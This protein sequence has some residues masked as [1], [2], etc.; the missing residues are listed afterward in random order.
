MKNLEPKRDKKTVKALWR[1]TSLVVQ[2]LV[3]QWLV[4]QWLAHCS[5]DRGRVPSLVRELDPTGH[6][7]DLA[8]P[9]K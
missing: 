5:Q 2:W 8:Q 1:G 3:V 9:N 7:Q 4:V 6:N